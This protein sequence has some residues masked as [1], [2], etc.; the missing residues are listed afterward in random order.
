MKMNYIKSAPHRVS[1]KGYKGSDCTVNAIGNTLGISYDLARKLLQTGNFEDGKFSFRMKS[2]RTKNEF[3]QRTNVKNILRAISTDYCVYLSD[4]EIQKK[5]QNKKRITSDI[6]KT[7]RQSV[8]K[9]AES[10]PKGTFIILVF[11]HLTAVIDGVLVDTWNCGDYA[12]EIA[13]RINVPKARKV[14]KGLASFYKMDSESH[15]I[16][17]HKKT[18]LS[19]PMQAS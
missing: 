4:K 10:N 13:Y 3:T 14:I 9:F 2:P 1:I 16:K 17:N 8:N 19:K 6:K 18:L 5:I 11:G 12:V 7:G 15:F